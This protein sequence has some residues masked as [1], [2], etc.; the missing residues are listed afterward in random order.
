MNEKLDKVI[1]YIEDKREREVSK[2][3]GQRADALFKEDCQIVWL[4]E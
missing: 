4:D 3:E 2:V 1:A